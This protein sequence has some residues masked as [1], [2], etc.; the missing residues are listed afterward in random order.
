MTKFNRQSHRLKDYDYSSGGF[1]FITLCT[2]ERKALFGTIQKGKM[3]LN[4]FGAIVFQQWEKT[5]DIRPYV[6]LDLWVVMPNHFHALLALIPDDKDNHESTS[7]PSHLV[8]KSIGAIVSGFK[9]AATRQI[10]QL[11]HSKHPPI[12]QRNYHDHIVRDKK[13]PATQLFT[14][15]YT[16]VFI[17]SYTMKKSR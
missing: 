14:V 12:W 17:L 11:R 13:A 3:I 10:N 1:Y 6:Q 5:A 9:S 15:R 7:V 8:S 4:G 2:H 16:L